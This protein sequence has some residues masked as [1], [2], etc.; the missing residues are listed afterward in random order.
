M[1]QKR[2][3]AG[4]ART[5]LGPSLQRSPNSLT[6]FKRKGR[7]KGRAKRQGTWTRGLDRG[8]WGGRGGLGEDGESR[9]MVI[10]KS[11]RMVVSTSDGLECE[12][13]LAHGEHH[14]ISSPVLSGEAYVASGFFVAQWNTF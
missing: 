11:R 1:H 4:F 12:E 9:P 2:L 5:R 13:G 10:S 8:L 3:T 14:V 6:G 7:D